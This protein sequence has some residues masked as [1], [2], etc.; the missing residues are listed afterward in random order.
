MRY[1]LL[2]QMAINGHINRSIIKNQF[3]LPLQRQ[4]ILTV[5]PVILFFIFFLCQIQK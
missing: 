3:R 1:N 5:D 2:Q 4:Q